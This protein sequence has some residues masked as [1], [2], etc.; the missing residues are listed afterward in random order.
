MK[1]L[2]LFLEPNYEKLALEVPDKVKDYFY[3][4][5]EAVFMQHQIDTY[6]ANKDF[7]V[8]INTYA[9]GTGKTRASLLNLINQPKENALF[10]AP[11]NELISQHTK[12][13]KNFI[14]SID[15]AHLVIEINAKILD[16]LLEKVEI[17]RRGEILYRLLTNPQNV[18]FASILE[19][20]DLDKKRPFIIITNPDIFYYAITYNYNNHDKRNIFHAIFSTF[21]YIIIDEFHYYNPKQLCCFLFFISLSLKFGHFR[22]GKK[23][24]I[25]TA[26]PLP[27]VRKYFERLQEEG[28]KYIILEPEKVEKNDIQAVKTLSPIKTTFFPTESF[29]FTKAIS[30]NLDFI[31]DKYFNNNDGVIISNSLININ[32]CYN[33]LKSKTIDDLGLITGVIDKKDRQNS[34]KKK[35]ILAT[36]TVDIGYNF[37]KINKT[38]QNIDYLIFDFKY[39]DQF[40]Q[41]LGRA[42]RVLGKEQQDELSEVI[43]FCTQDEI[44]KLSTFFQENQ[45]LTRQELNKC[46]E[47][48]EIFK[49]RNDLYDYIS[50]Y[51][52]S[53]FSK[54]L[55][56]LKRTFSKDK[57]YIVTENLFNTL[58][59]I[60]LG[61]ETNY[62]V[63]IQKI[64]KRY[65]V[66]AKT[67]GNLEKKEKIERNDM[68]SIH[69]EF[70]EICKN[71]ISSNQNEVM[72]EFLNYVKE[73]Y[74]FLKGFY[75]FRD[76]FQGINI[77][78]FD[79]EGLMGF[80]G[81]IFN[82]D[83][84]HILKYYNLTFF[85]TKEDFLITTKTKDLNIKEKDIFYCRIDS[86][87][88]LSQSI[89]FSI[90]S[91]L[92][93]E[94]FDT[95]YVN[96]ALA[97]NN[98]AF[99]LF[100][101]TKTGKEIKPFDIKLSKA[102]EKFKLN[103][104]PCIILNSEFSAFCYR[105]NIPTFDLEVNINSVSYSYKIV[106]GVNAYLIAP[107]IKKI[108]DIIEKQTQFYVC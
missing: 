61:K 65:D 79:P 13:V 43:V 16:E 3:K 100:T 29:G 105:N 87:I 75:N 97:K 10:I 55:E 68:L 18:D 15:L 95:R 54:P 33:Y 86:R 84:F 38:R 35:I 59:N 88:D 74:Y 90:D 8:V 63:K 98:I 64:Y 73:E 39:Q 7:D 47:K 72:Q 30:G 81:K 45:V 62:Y 106:F 77:K 99:R 107:K 57:E 92:S 103:Y 78:V 40:W 82:Y 26:T 2:T 11:T 25:L 48:N 52:L 14:S 9:T 56:E 32:D 1:S 17:S 91:D 89:C 66:L 23:I 6:N 53:E 102:I 36:P 41:R 44:N 76:S 83:L 67:I 19:I 49:F 60:F 101:N 31:S 104:I 22:N 85:E 70:M 50:F 5:P 108:V 94:D 24:T 21:F 93:K 27:Q 34:A 51:G 96:K 4:N 69:K 42:G 28:L 20:S 37:D 12:D 80:E 58:S 71:F 46:I